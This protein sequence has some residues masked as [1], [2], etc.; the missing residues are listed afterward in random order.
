MIKNQEDQGEVGKRRKNQ[1]GTRGGDK[2][3]KN[4]ETQKKIEKKTMI[5]SNFK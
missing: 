5:T 2:P 3:T 4:W 1:G